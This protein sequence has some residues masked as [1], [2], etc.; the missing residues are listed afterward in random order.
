MT[1]LQA[2]FLLGLGAAAGITLGAI[3]AFEPARPG[4]GDLPD[5]AVARVNNKT[6]TAEALSRELKEATDD[7]QDGGNSEAHARILNQL[8]DQELLV[9][10]GLAIGLVDSNRAV[11]AAI[12]KA[13]IESILAGSG[14]TQPSEKALREFFEEQYGSHNRFLFD[15]LRDQVEAAYQRSAEEK[16]VRDYLDWLWGEADIETRPEESR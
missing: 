1:K 8:I 4:P 16:A 15:Q 13:V 11:R 2:R 12:A 3:G 14:D 9:Q 5:G 10:H 6:I 7:H